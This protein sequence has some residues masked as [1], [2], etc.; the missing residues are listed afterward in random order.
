VQQQVCV[1]VCALWCIYMCVCVRARIVKQYA[2]ISIS[3]IHFTKHT[4][5]HTHLHT[6][7]HTQVANQIQLYKDLR[8]R[9]VFINAP[10]YT[11]FLVG[12]NK[13]P[14]GYNENQFSLPRWCVCVC[15]CVYM[16]VCMCVCVHMYIYLHG[17][18]SVFV[19]MYVCVCMCVCGHCAGK[20]FS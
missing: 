11:Y 12:V 16:C 19:C 15:M 9:G 14:M 10:D 8:N 7:T 17:R 3:Q 2:C 13:A 1:C 6:Y 18:S 5:T 4:H 20:M